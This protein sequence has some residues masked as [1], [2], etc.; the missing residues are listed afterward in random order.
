MSGNVVLQIATC[1][2]LDVLSRPENGM[3]QRGVLEGCG[4]QVVKHDLLRNALNL[5]VCIY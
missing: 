4:M 5:H 1:K 2:L 3:A